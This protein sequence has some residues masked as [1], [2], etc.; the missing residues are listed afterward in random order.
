IAAPASHGAGLYMLAA[1]LKGAQVVIT[2]GFDLEETEEVLRTH[3]QVSLFAVPTILNRLVSAWPGSDV[4]L[5]NLRTIVYGGA[6][7]YVADL[8]RAIDLFGQRLFQL[9][10]QGESPMT[11]SGLPRR[12]HR[13]D[14]AESARL[15]GSCGYP[16]TGALVRIRDPETG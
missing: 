11:I 4:P 15:L 3:R 7:M 1:L 9:F 12:L 14:L 16:R 5:E 13:R 8:E 10:A 2:P 6:P